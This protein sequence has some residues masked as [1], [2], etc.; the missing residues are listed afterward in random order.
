MEPRPA[1]TANN[2]FNMQRIIRAV[3]VGKAYKKSVLETI[4][5]K[6]VTL[7]VN[8]GEFICVMGPS[9]CGK[10]T[11]LNLLGLLDVPDSGKIYLMGEDISGASNHHRATIRRKDIGFVFQNFNLIEELTLY[12][13]I[14][15]PLVYQRVSKKER[16]KAVT[17][18]LEKMQLNHKRRAFPAELS[19]GQQQRGAIARAM[20]GKPQIV[21]ADEP[22]G[23]LDS[24]QGQEIMEMLLTLNN[25]GTTVIMATHSPDATDYCSRVIKLFDGQI[26]TENIKQNLTTDT[27]SVS[28][29]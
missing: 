14:E 12:E 7:E 1:G 6:D 22:T 15:L 23:N 13:N 5:L 24:I 4:A 2:P 9:G 20:I 28:R 10:T 3:N 18:L 8:E 25:E 16:K 29:Q 26:V 21:F 19:G 27:F 17:G 11:L